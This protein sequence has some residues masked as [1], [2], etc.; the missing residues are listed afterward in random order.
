MFTNFLFCQI[1][2]YVLSAPPMNYYS[3]HHHQLFLLLL[4]LILTSTLTLYC[5]SLICIDWIEVM[6]LPPAKPSGINL[7]AL[8]R[9]FTNVSAPFPLKLESLLSPCLWSW[10]LK[11]HPLK[12]A[13][14]TILKIIILLIGLHNTVFIPLN[15]FFFPLHETNVFSGP[16]YKAS[17][18]WSPCAVS[19]ATLNAVILKMHDLW[20]STSL[21]TTFKI[22]SYLI[23][24]S[25][26]K[27]ESLSPFMSLS[28][29]P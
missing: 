9:P 17:Q 21:R 29:L 18:S 20:F 11:P 14:D 6:R 5:F 3:Q 24:Y 7:S 10:H 26:T 2:L 15:L 27:E 25:F 23:V 22:L 19:R 16:C 13:L 8:P 4:L 12:S 1:L 28:P